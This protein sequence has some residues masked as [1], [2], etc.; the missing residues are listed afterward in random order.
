MQQLLINNSTMQLFCG[1]KDN[2]QSLGEMDLST[3]NL[4]MRKRKSGQIKVVVA[5]LARVIQAAWM[6]QEG[7]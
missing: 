6:K 3:S 5:G 7:I 1:C 4:H 2:L